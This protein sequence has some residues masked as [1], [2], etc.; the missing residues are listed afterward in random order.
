MRS[1]IFTLIHND[2]EFQISS[3]IRD[4][5]HDLIFCIHGL[6]CAKENF[7]EIWGIDRL[8]RFSILAFDLPGFGDSSKPSNFSYDLQDQAAVCAELL[9]NFPGRHIHLVCHSMGG[10]IGLIL[11]DLIPGRLKSFANI[12]GNLTGHD[13]TVSRKQSLASLEEFK[14][15]E[16]PGLLLITSISPE[17]GTRLW[18]RL[19]KKADIKSMYLSSRSLVRW[20]DAGMLLDKFKHLECKKIY[21]YGENDSFLKI[22]TMLA[23][24]PARSISHSGHFPMND[25]PGEFYTFLADFLLKP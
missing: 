2:I 1:K 5:G 24:V 18:S 6:G 8:G 12:E 7:N 4:T 20:S 25:N 10:A 23:P 16:L 15:K 17:P 13:C 11:A 9:A 21:V 19:I 3:R 22:L 14:K